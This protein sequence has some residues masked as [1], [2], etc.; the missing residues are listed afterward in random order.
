MASRLPEARSARI[1]LIVALL[2]AIALP[3]LSRAATRISV[4]SVAEGLTCQCGCGLTVANCNHPQCEF[5]VPVRTQIEAMIGR[6]MTRTQIIATF[7]AKYGEKIL[8]APTTEGFNL[9]AWL[10]PFG[11][12]LAG[13]GLLVA[14]VGRWRSATL[15][16]RPA[17]PDD[18]ARFDPQ[19]RE[20][21][22]SEIKENL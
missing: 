7:R 20:R 9:L 17:A 15:R 18:N 12:I 19:L 13:C 16:P 11:M 6:G 14:V 1:A 2:C 21:L 5:S 8:S 4:D 10:M 22:E 3:V